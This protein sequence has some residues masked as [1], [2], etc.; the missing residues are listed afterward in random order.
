[1][2]KSA[3]NFAV[4][5]SLIWLCILYSQVVYAAKAPLV[6]GVFPR[7]EVPTSDKS[8]QPISNYLSKR[9]QR[10]VRLQ[11]ADNFQSFWRGVVEKKYDIVH[12]NQYHYI[13]SNKKFG[14]KVILKNE[15]FGSLKMAGGIAVRKDSGIRSVADLRGKKIVFGG[16]RRAMMG[17][18]VPRYLLLQEG[19]NQGDY[20]ESF[21]KNPPNA[22]ISAFKKQSDAAGAGVIVLQSGFIKKRIDTQELRILVKSEPITQMPWAVKGTMAVKLKRQI[23]RAMIALNQ[24]EQGKFIL[25]A[26]KLTGISKATDAEFNPHRNISK[27]VFGKK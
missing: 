16:G 10:N 14:Y 8:F 1:M 13:I 11:M 5:A 19:L 21:V 26:A 18:I 24:S 20:I 23:Q 17:Y 12:Y 25:N 22:I 9:L 3:P 27:A 6:L 4:L 7:G 2:R 15:E